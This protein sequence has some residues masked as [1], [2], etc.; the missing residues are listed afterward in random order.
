MARSAES[1]IGKREKE[2]ALA[3]AYANPFS[4]GEMGGK[5]KI[6][7]QVQDISH[8]TIAANKVKAERLKKD[9]TAFKSAISARKESTLGTREQTGGSALVGG[10][11]ATIPTLTSALA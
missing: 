2:L 11:V 7:G 10:S 1:E 8:E 4:V 5:V 9:L 6:D 3:E